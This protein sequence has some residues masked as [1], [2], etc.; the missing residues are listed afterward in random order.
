M[1]DQLLFEGEAPKKE[2]RVSKWAKVAEFYE[3]VKEITPIKAEKV[4][5]SSPEFGDREGNTLRITFLDHNYGD[6][7]RTYENCF[8][9]FKEDLVRQRVAVG[10][11]YLVMCWKDGRKYIW[12]WELKQNETSANTV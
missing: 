11:K 1:T 8:P 2:S 10:K 9:S 3:K 4:Q 7:E 6:A 5:A 12:K